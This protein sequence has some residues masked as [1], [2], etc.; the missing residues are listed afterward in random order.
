MLHVQPEFMKNIAGKTVAHFVKV[1]AGD[2]EMWP[3]LKF[4]DGSILVIQRDP[5]GNGGGFMN[6]ESKNGE[7]LGCAGCS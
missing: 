4:T 6:L 3:G 1:D 2:G 7:Q 5:E